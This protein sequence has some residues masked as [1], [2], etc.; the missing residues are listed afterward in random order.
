MKLEE[1]IYKRVFVI[2]GLNQETNLKRAGDTRWGSHYGTIINLI[3]M[4]LSVIDVLEIVQEDGLHTEQIVEAHSL[5]DS[6]QSFEFVFNLHL[7]KNILGIRHELSF[8][9]RRKYQDIVNAMTLVKVSKQRLQMMRDDEWG[10]LLEEVYLFYSEH[11]I[12]IPHID[13]RFAARRR[14]R[15]KAPKIT[16]LYHYHVDIFY[17]IMQLQELTEASTELLLCMAC[18]NPNNSFCAFDKQRLIHLA[19]FYPYDFS[20]VDLMALDNQLQHFIVD[21]HSSNGFSELKG[22]GD[23]I[24]KLV[25]TKKDIICPLI[26]FLVKLA[27]ILPVATAIVEKAF[28]TIKF[29]KNR[30]RNRLEDQWLNDYLVTYI[31]KDVFDS[32]DN[33]LIMHRF[34]NMKSHRDQL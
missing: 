31:E 13:D 34:Q 22:I 7:I 27:L 16:N 6:M 3:L 8:A 19:E 26:Y 15:R 29:M 14:S 25:E 28:S 5:I 10:S 20:T 11:D 30:L 17:T 2:Q 33:E 4:F 32:V 24:R 9:P 1:H 12:P 21:V 18:L 23:L